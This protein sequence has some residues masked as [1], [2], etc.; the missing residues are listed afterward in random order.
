MTQRSTAAWSGS[1]RVTLTLLAVVPAAMA[2]PWQTTR[3]RWLLGVAVVVVVLLLGRWHGLHLTT[4]LRRRLTIMRREPQRAHGPRIEVQTTEL[5][6]VSAPAG[7]PDMLPLPL[8]AKY[9]DCYGIRADAIR[10]TSRDAVSDNGALQR[11]TWIGMTVLALEN[12]PA[13]RARS[14]QIPL[15]ETAGIA[16]R[17]LADELREIGWIVA[18]VGPDDVPRVSAPSA[19]ETWSGLREGGAGYVA[20]YQLRVDR[21]LPDTLAAIRSHQAQETWTAIEVAGTSERRTLAA[22]C[23]FRSDS[24]PGSTAPVPGL[25]PQRGHHRATLI[26]LDSLSA[27]RLHG[28]TDLPAGLLER[29]PWPTAATAARRAAAALS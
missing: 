3:D 13:L 16:M 27:R 17:R 4:I 15:Q 26:A 8:I 7:S 1:G 10:V 22:V 29:L 18:T 2:Y 11:K 28:H 24:R 20:A 14:A 6:R 25:T 9:V 12:L 21:K 5:L 23:A 19:R